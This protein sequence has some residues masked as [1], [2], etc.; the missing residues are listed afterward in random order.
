MHGFLC[1]EQS[2]NYWTAHYIP[3]FFYWN[4]FRRTNRYT[5]CQTSHYVYSLFWTTMQFLRNSGRCIK[6]HRPFPIPGYCYNHRNLLFSY[7]LDIYCFQAIL[8]VK[9]S[10]LCFSCFMDTNVISY[11][12]RLCYNKTNKVISKYLL[13]YT[14][15]GRLW[16]FSCP[17]V[18]AVTV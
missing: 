17:T 1:F 6:R 12:N 13:F 2:D 16:K 15:I 18:P 7:H 5:K 11:Y 8:P 14:L 9:Y 3:K 4:F 10:V